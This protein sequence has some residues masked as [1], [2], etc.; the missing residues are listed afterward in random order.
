MAKATK[1]QIKY[2][3]ALIQKASIEEKELGLTTAK[4]Q[5]GI[6]DEWSAVT[7]E[8]LGNFR[9]EKHEISTLIDVLA[10][11]ECYAQPETEEE[12]E[13]A[14]MRTEYPESKEI[15]DA[16]AED[17]A[18][19]KSLESFCKSLT[20]EQSDKLKWLSATQMGKAM[21]KSVRDEH[22]MSRFEYPAEVRDAILK[23]A[24]ARAIWRFNYFDELGGSD[25]YA[26]S[27]LDWEE[28][29]KRFK[30]NGPVRSIEE[31]EALPV[32][33]LNGA[34]DASMRG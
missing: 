25:E 24:K 30:R 34:V 26:V 27:L 4:E 3:D 23:A 22:V 12:A 19:R 31:L 9:W 16:T 33:K 10:N 1:A 5:L 13:L 14:V 32:N 7:A 2:L 28:F 17:I 18:D 11:P 20:G 6:T 15:A 29:W 8:R 21:M